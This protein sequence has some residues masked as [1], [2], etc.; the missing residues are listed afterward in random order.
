M[1]LFSAVLKKK[2]FFFLF[3]F[4]HFLYLVSL[5]YQ[6]CFLPPPPSVIM[7]CAHQDW[8]INPVFKASAFFPAYIQFSVSL[9]HRCFRE[10]SAPLPSHLLPKHQPL[11]LLAVIPDLAFTTYAHVVVHLHHVSIRIGVSTHL[12]HCPIRS[13]TCILLICPYKVI[14]SFPCFIYLWLYNMS[15]YHGLFMKVSMK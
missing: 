15:L 6:S 3:Y 5:W 11:Y 9:Y 12:F 14:S 1:I 2:I 8:G 7:L 13:G 10:V 4:S